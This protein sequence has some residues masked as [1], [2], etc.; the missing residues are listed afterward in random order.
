M[1]WRNSTSIGCGRSFR[2]DRGWLVVCLFDPKGNIA[3]RFGENVQVESNSTD[4]AGKIEVG[5]ARPNAGTIGESR[6]QG[7]GIMDKIQ[8]WCVFIVVVLVIGAVFS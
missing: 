8:I 7:G 5:K 6:S 3:G 2:G 4:V 1:V